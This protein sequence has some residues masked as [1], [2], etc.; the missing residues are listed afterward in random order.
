MRAFWAAM[1]LIPMGL[2]SASAQQIEGLAKTVVLHEG[3]TVTVRAGE[4][5]LVRAAV[6]VQNVVS[7][8]KADSRGN[9]GARRSAFQ[10]LPRPFVYFGPG[11]MGGG[12]APLAATAG[13]GFRIDSR[14]LL[15]N[16]EGSYDNGH[17]ANDNTQPNPKGHDRG[18][19]G[20]AYYR[21]SSG[22]FLGAGARW[23]QLS[24]TNYTKTGSRPT[25]GG[26]K[27]Y[28]HRMNCNG[29][30]ESCV[31][32]SMRIGV[33]YVLKGNDYANGS[34]GPLV[35]FYMPSPTAKGHFFFRQALG[36]YSFYDTV[37]D[38][39][40][41]FLTHEQMGNRHVQAIAELTLMYR[42]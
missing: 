31:D 22:W 12:Y 14:H 27:D 35:T 4:T 26:G 29:D 34:Q 39:T 36:I 8:R 38:P 9:Q 2:A 23:S 25:F 7:A 33:D 17:K 24:T 1:F 42:F 20:S 18:L 3:E 37:T 16:F 32:F 10:F 19:A 11:L 30:D 41:A 5:V 13:A 28:L 15:V 40:N 21:L 6:P